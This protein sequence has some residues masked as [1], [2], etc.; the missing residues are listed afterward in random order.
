MI[1]VKLS[2]RSAAIP[3]RASDVTTSPRHSK[4]EWAAFMVSRLLRGIGLVRKRRFYRIRPDV[5]GKYGGETAAAAGETYTLGV[6]NTL[7]GNAWREQMIC[8]IKAEAAA[9]G[10]IDKVILANRNASTTEQIAD[11]QGLISQGV[12]AIIINPS[13][14]EA[15]NPVIQAATSQGIVVVT[16]D[17][18]VTEILPGV[19]RQIPR[20]GM[21]SG[22]VGRH[23]QYAITRPE[24]FQRRQK[25][26]PERI[27][28][29]AIGR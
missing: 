5:E 2:I 16:I 8:A 23:S 27:G 14:R 9:S 28:I 29:Q 21:E 26:L 6:S 15:L 11:I 20:K 10:V 4:M 25:P 12:D 24:L 22:R 18:A 3:A 13:D 17:Q 7:V 1:Q 19:T